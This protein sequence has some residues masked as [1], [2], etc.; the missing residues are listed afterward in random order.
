MGY[1][2]AMLLSMLAIKVFMGDLGYRLGTNAIKT[3]SSQ[4]SKIS[5]AANIV[6]VT[7]IS[8]LAASF[9][10]AK[11]AIQYATTVS[12]GEEQVVSIQKILD[13]MMPRLLPVLITVLVYYLLKKKKW[14]TYQLLILLFVIGILASVL[15]ILA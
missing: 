4:I 10:K 13:K 12:S 11:I 3:L 2:F 8:A 5:E 14:N 1:W 15:G 7:V 6:G 9:V